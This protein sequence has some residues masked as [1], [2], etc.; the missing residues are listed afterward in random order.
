M[1]A[2]DLHQHLWP[3]ALV[4][5][6]RRRTRAPYLRGW[7]LV[8]EGEPAYEIQ[9]RDHAVG[10]RFELD[11]HAGIGLACV[12][13]SAPLG[14][15]SLPRDEAGALIDAWHRGARDLPGHFAAWASVPT[16]E[17][18]VAELADLLNGPFVGVQLPATALSSPDDWHALGEVLRVAELADKPV[19]IHPGPAAAAGAVPSWWAPVVDYVAQ[20]QAAWWA[21]HAFDGRAHFPRLRL[22]FAAGAGLAP[23]HHERLAA[24]GGRFGPVDPDVFVDT[25]SYGAQ[26][27][28]ALV[29]ALG[30]DVLALGSD[31]PYAE[32]LSSLLGDAATQA[33]RVDN[34]RRALGG[35]PRTDLETREA[36]KTAQ[37]MEAVA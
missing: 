6:L 17:P 22:V 35:H 27:L 23:V 8:T 1:H 16:H 37:I 31:R 28:D 13:L 20:L 2:V 25:S 4:E 26:G 7:Q 34:P 33:I 30:I 15:E 10:R 29:R 14:I 3:E 36:L 12:S 19:F 18:D 11:R 9:P 21:W 24:R 5:Q 32:P